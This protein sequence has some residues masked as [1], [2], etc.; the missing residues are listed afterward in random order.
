MYP[1]RKNG[2]LKA[3]GLET[4]LIGAGS[5]IKQRAFTHAVALVG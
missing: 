4:A 2:E 1:L 5:E 3:R